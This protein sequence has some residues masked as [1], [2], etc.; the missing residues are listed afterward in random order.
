MTLSKSRMRLVGL[1]CRFARSQTASN[2]KGNVVVN[3]GPPN[4]AM[5]MTIWQGIDP[6]KGAQMVS[7]SPKNSAEPLPEI[8]PI[9]VYPSELHAGELRAE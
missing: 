9:F 7:L 5:R 2:Y 4:G 3:L 8:S 6:D 1:S